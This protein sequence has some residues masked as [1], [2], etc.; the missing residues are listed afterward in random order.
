MDREIL[1]VVKTS[2]SVQRASKCMYIFQ[3]IL[4]SIFAFILVGIAAFSAIEE[5]RYLGD[6]VKHWL[7]I[8]IV[9]KI[10][11]WKVFKKWELEDAELQFTEDTLRIVKYGLR[12]GLS[13]NAV[14]VLEVPYDKIYR[15]EYKEREQCFLLAGEIICKRYRRFDEE[16][17]TGKGFAYF[18]DTFQGV[19][20]QK[21]NAKDIQENIQ[22][23]NKYLKKPVIEE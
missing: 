1:E 21:H 16:R 17:G 2:H 10:P 15:C 20:W 4:K 23:L 3:W 8:Y 14:E 5:Y 9:M 19:I 13:L 12:R 7:I 6:Y 11:F 22:A 18:V